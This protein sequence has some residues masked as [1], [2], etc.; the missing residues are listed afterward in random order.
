VVYNDW[1]MLFNK[2]KCKVLHLSSNNGK[3]D[4]M[5]GD[6]VLDSVG[7]SIERDLGVLYIV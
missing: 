5:L 6:Q 2:D 3:Y 7:L 1:L 4:Y